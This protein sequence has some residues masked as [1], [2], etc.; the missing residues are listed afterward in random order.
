MLNFSFILFLLLFL[1]SKLCCLI[2]SGLLFRYSKACL[3]VL[4][5]EILNIDCSCFLNSCFNNP[6]SS[7]KVAASDK[8]ES[9]ASTRI[10]G[11]KSTKTDISRYYAISVM[12]GILRANHQS[13]G[14]G[15]LRQLDFVVRA[16]QSHQTILSRAR[17]HAK[18]LVLEYQ[19]GSSV[20]N[21]LEGERTG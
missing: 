6:A 1:Q 5:K 18:I 8:G 16:V 21:R 19:I 14:A 15:M 10:L 9:H 2:P 11:K 4:K 12:T 7:G 20:G 17:C 3:E 13:D